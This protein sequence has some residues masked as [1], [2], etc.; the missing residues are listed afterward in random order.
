ML[1]EEEIRTS[2]LFHDATMKDRHSRTGAVSGLIFGLLDGTR[3]TKCSEGPRTYSTTLL[4]QLPVAFLLWNTDKLGVSS[5]YA[6][7]LHRSQRGN[8]LANPKQLDLGGCNPD[9]KYKVQLNM[10]S[11]AA[12]ERFAKVP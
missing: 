10:L 2:I 11:T 4:T 5:G 8:V 12:R 9:L 7:P 6:H 3:S 1:D